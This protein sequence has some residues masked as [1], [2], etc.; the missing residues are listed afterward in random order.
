MSPRSFA[1]R[2]VQE[3][4][5]TP[6][7]WLSGQR[8]LLAQQLLEETGETVD[9]VA[10]RGRVRERDSPAPPLPHL[11]AHDTARIPARVPPGWRRLEAGTKAPD[12]PGGPLAGLFQPPSWSICVGIAG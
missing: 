4:G 3:T 11:E 1:R 12:R 8:I 7:R 10:E 2:F 6:H 9:A 5:T